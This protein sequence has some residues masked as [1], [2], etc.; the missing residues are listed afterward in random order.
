MSKVSIIIPFFNSEKSIIYCLQSVLNQTFNDFEIILIDDGSKDSSINLI[1]EFFAQNSF[2]N[3]RIISQNNSGPGIARNTGLNNSTSDLVAFLDSDDIW[4]N[5]H[6]S[7][8]IDYIEN[9]DVDLVCTNKNLNLKKTKIIKLR[10]MMFR[11]YIQ[12]SSMLA[13]KHIF[14]NNQ[15]RAGKRYSEDYD[16]WL[17]LSA[18]KKRIVCLPVNDVRNI[19]NKE[20]FGVSGLSKNL[21]KM[22]KNE[23]DNYLYLLKTGNVSFILFSAAFVFSLFKYIMRCIKVFHK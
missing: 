19:D 14:A 4:E 7:L 6:L 12:S 13:K 8:L 1:K 17:R 5:N 3:Y 11:C 21:W 18:E 2:N 9:N 20:S 23:L 16:L 10:N 15:F 22:E